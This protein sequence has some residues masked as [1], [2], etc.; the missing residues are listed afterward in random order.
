MNH[1]GSD[2][3]QLWH[4]ARGLAVCAVLAGAAG[5]YAFFEG[6]RAL[7]L[8]FILGGATSILRYRFRYSALLKM[9]AKGAGVAVRSRFYGYA[10]NAVALAVAFL[11]RPMISPWSTIAGL[12]VMN[13]C[14]VAAEFMTPGSE[15]AEDRGAES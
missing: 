10:A 7:A 6:G 1:T 3:Q 11:A 13:A 9:Q 2:L 14:V 15:E 12:F 4:A 8:G 5:L